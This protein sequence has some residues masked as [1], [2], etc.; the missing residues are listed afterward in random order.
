MIV[1]WRSEHE[2]EKRDHEPSN[3][4]HPEGDLDTRVVV[5]HAPPPED[6]V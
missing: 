3:E 2:L 5:L 1:A 4:Q 6:D